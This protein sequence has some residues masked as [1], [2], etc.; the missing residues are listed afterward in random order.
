[1]AR[2]VFSF[3][4]LEGRPPYAAPQSGPRGRCLCAPGKV[5]PQATPLQPEPDFL[6]RCYSNPSTALR[7]SEWPR[8]FVLIHEANS[9]NLSKSAPSENA[10]QFNR[11]DQ[12]IIKRM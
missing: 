6:F 8:V 2:S 10:Y 7:A 5:V 3:E 9:Q 4:R 11:G 1:V 12:K